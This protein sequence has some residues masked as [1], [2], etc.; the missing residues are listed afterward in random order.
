MKRQKYIHK[1]E[2][3]LGQKV[4]FCAECGEDLSMFG[5]ESFDVDKVKE[6][7]Q[8][9]REI[10]KFNGDKCAMLF[11]AQSNDDLLDDFESE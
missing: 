7:H 10:G 2:N 6:R 5:V 9:C 11:I 8:H 4:I 1:K 3:A